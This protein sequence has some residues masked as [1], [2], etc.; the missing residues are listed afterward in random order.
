MAFRSKGKVL[1]IVALAAAAQ[2]P[3]AVG[4]SSS[5]VLKLDEV[6]VTSRKVEERL[7]D[8][9]LSIKAFGGE[10]IEREG[11]SRIEDVA[12]LVPGLTYDLG[13]FPNDTRPAIRGMQSERGRPSVA[14]LLDGQDIGGEN[15]Y[16]AGGSA[17]LN[18]RLLDLE[19]I[20][21]VKGPQSVLYGRSAF[22][23]AINYISKRP[24]LDEWNGKF[25]TVGF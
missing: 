21:V 24:S 7:Q 18:T 5:D 2:A 17:S 8:V 14:V 23:G 19:R 25:E 15:L 9:P 22:S 12:R 16:I 1:S 13:A 3:F 10:Q 4:Q 6:V 11:I 20:E